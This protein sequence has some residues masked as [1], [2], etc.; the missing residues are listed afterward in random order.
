MKPIWEKSTAYDLFRRYV[1]NVTRS[2]YK[3]IKVEGRENIPSDGCVIF[4]AN[5]CN[6]LMDALVVLRTQKGPMAFGARADIFNNP[7]AAKILNFLRIVPLARTRDGAKAI[8]GNYETFNKVVDCLRHGVPFGLYPEGKHRTKHSLQPIK[9]GVFRIAI[10]ACNETDLPVYVV[11]VGLEYSDYF[12]FR[13]NLEI[14]FGKPLDV[15]AYLA[16]IGDEAQ[17]THKMLEVLYERIAANILFF[18]DDENYDNAWAEYLNAHLPK[19]NRPTKIFRKVLAVLSLPFFILF[20]LQSFL[21]WIPAE[22]LVRRLKD[23]AWSNTVRFCCK[24]L[25]MPLQLA[26]IAVPS[27]ILLPWWAAVPVVFASIFGVNFFYDLINY[28]DI[29]LSEK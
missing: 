20:A 1:D 15:R 6:T 10:Q 14:K 22:I 7:T 19:Y 23:K 17:A 28:Y 11:P 3:S 13:A 5:H 4:A 29:V 26:V 25:M 21:I 27:F 12:H 24:L 2:S 8:E 9:K 16:E 18:P